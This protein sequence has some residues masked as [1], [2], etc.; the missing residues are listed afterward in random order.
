MLVP[1]CAEKTVGVSTKASKFLHSPQES[2]E[3]V[4][5]QCVRV[6]ATLHHPSSASDQPI[7]VVPGTTSASGWKQERLWTHSVCAGQ[8]LEREVKRDWCCHSKLLQQP[9]GAGQPK[10]RRKQYK[11]MHRSMVFSTQEP[12]GGAALLRTHF[13]LYYYWKWSRLGMTA[14]K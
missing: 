8:S 14:A 5:V 12:Q 6:L 1:A 10:S 3:A 13:L 11:L 2:G 4:V 9:S 7:W